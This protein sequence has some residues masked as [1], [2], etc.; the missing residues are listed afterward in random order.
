MRKRII[1]FLFFSF[2]LALCVCART[3]FSAS[4][5]D[6]LEK[7]YAAIKSFQAD[8][9]QRL[10]HFDSGSEEIR[11]GVLFFQK[12]MRI[13]WETAKPNEE[14]II[15]SEK[16]VWNYL[17]AEK[18]AVRYAPD[19][20]PE[21]RSVM[22]VLTG[23]SKLSANYNVTEEGKEGKLIRL[24][25][26]PDV[27]TTQLTEAILWADEN[28]KQIEKMQIIDFYG[29][30]NEITF[31]NLRINPS[32]SGSTFTFTPPVGANVQDRQNTEESPIF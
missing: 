21:T 1:K 3:A 8:F 31:R 24:R 11:A 30:I 14:L 2:T 9:T 22:E 16:E 27:P 6:D 29:N 10:V 23:Q 25:L 12:P 18:S 15:I 17:P 32:L 13:R 28:L 26:L 7:H 4:F 20:S 19:L 5:A